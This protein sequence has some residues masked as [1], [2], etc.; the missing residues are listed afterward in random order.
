MPKLSIK[1][2]FSCFKLFCRSYMSLIWSLRASIRSRHCRQPRVVRGEFIFIK[3]L[4]INIYK[5]VR[6]LS[7]FTINDQNA[8]A[9]ITVLWVHL[10]KFSL[11]DGYF[12]YLLKSFVKISV[13][14]LVFLVTN[15]SLHAGISGEEKEDGFDQK[16]Y[17]F[18]IISQL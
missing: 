17:I 15:Y 14:V 1:V 2:L 12:L 3:F 8:D 16:S 6:L 10:I 11:F 5:T 13:W 9:F 7:F 4:S 18:D